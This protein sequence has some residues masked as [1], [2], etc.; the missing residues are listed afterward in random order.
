MSIATSPSNGIIEGEFESDVEVN[1]TL[2]Q[3]NSSEIDMQIATAK[4]Y[5][6]AVT[7]F[8]RQ[9]TEFATLDENTAASM[10]YKL[11]RGRGSDGQA[12]FIEGPSVRLAE[13]AASC[14]K[15]LRFGSRIISVEDRFITAQGFCFDLENNTAAAVE[16]RRR[17]T[18]SNGARF[19]DDMIQV[20]GA[21]ASSIALRNAIFRIIPKAYYDPALNEAKLTCLGK[22]KTMAER[23]ENALGW[24][25]KA[26][27]TDQQ[28]FAALGVKGEADIGNDE[29]ITLRGLV[30]AIKEG[31]ITLETA[32]AAPETESG[33]KVQASSL[34]ERLKASKKSKPLPEPE[35]KPETKLDKPLPA[36]PC[37]TGATEPMESFW[38]KMAALTEDQALRAWSDEIAKTAALGEGEK[39]ELWAEISRRVGG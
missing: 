19:N 3:L 17:I 24:F 16:V 30:T 20:T 5:P 18:N 25:K 39:K 22:N 7:T 29:L 13:V 1:G 21:A 28:V 37:P 23:R 11:P 34:N 14:Y 36:K 4:K 32:L 6:R 2:A 9:V 31:S 33:S 26:G 12:K 38:N 8:M 15:N 27:A 10:F 35:T